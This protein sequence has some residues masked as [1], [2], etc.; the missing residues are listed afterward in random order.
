MDRRLDLRGEKVEFHSE[1]FGS[2]IAYAIDGRTLYPLVE[3]ARCIGWKNPG[4]MVKQCAARE[5]WKI[6]TARQVVTKNYIDKTEL[7]RLLRRCRSPSRE[8]LI[9]WLCGKGGNANGQRTH[10]DAQ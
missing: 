2:V 9:D 7:E 10:G 3:I 4:S 6:R 5:R 1:R 8:A